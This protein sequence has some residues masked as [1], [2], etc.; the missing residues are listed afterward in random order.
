MHRTRPQAKEAEAAVQNHATPNRGPKRGPNGREL[1]REPTHG[2]ES[3]PT[4]PL[5]QAHIIDLNRKERPTL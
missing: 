4:S 2:G 1:K 3:E 5:S